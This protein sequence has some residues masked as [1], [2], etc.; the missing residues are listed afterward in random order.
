M[1]YLRQRELLSW[2]LVGWHSFVSSSVPSGA[3]NVNWDELCVEPQPHSEATGR[4][5]SLRDHPE[6]ERRR[7]FVCV[8]VHR[9]HF[10]TLLR[11]GADCA[12]GGADRLVLLSYGSEVCEGGREVFFF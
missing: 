9:R 8:R 12:G 1:W 7:H 5:Q 3:I 4:A 6:M 10:T 2:I 11:T